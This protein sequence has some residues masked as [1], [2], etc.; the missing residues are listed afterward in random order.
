MKALFLD[1][2]FSVLVFLGLFFLIGILFEIATRRNSTFIDHY[3]SCKKCQNALGFDLCE[4]G[5]RLFDRDVK[6]GKLA[7]NCGKKQENP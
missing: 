4:Q 2:L 1:S 7:K 3:E 5:N 6:N